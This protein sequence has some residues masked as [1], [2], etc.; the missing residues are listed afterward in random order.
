MAN[1]CYWASVSVHVYAHVCVWLSDHVSGYVHLCAVGPVPLRGV[2]E[3]A[4]DGW[5]RPQAHLWLPSAGTPQGEPECWPLMGTP[6][7]TAGGLGPS[8]R[9]MSH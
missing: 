5:P 4:G 3:V 9:P 8:T 1:A 7:A 6:A 2:W